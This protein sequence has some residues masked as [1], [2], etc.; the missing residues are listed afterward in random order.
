[1]ALTISFYWLIFWLVQPFSFNANKALPALL[2]DDSK[3][4]V[5]FGSNF[6]GLSMINASHMT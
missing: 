5:K 3:D 6:Q 1:M 4:F 2:F